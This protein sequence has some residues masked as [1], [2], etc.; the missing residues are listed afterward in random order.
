MYSY[1]CKVT[2]LYGTVRYGTVRYGT[3]RYGTVL[4]GTV[5]VTVIVRVLAK[6]GFF[7]FD[8]KKLIFKL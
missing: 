5:L 4:Y 2:V 6:Q 1:F 8:Q 3:V 7:N